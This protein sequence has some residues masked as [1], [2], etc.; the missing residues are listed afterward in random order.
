VRLWIDTD[1]GDNPDDA[2][3][4]LCAANHPALELVGVSTTAGD[5]ERRAALAAA[6]VEAPVIM[7]SRPDD[8]ARALVSARL[9]ALLA[10]G[11]L[12]NIARL[13]SVG[14]TLPP[15][16]VMGGALAPVYHRG[17]TRVVEHNFASDPAAASVVIASTDATVVPLDATVAM[18]LDDAGCDALG[19]AAPVLVAEIEAWRARH[20]QPIVLHDPL[21]LLVCA[22]EPMV[23]TAPRTIT[24]D[25]HTGEVWG[26]A[27]GRK[28]AVVRDVD[29]ESAVHRVLGL[30]G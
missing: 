19:R 6:L 8:L 18:R 11:P 26:A 30:L 23:T 25:P 28:H 21:A 16:T 24:V 7:G 12:T 9:D 29:A 15:L 4:L 20:A 2:V 17:A 1:V 10:I 14:L 13:L 27:E 22:G 5:P 3:A